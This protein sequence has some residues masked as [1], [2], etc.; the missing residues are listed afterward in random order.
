MATPNPA[1]IQYQLLHIREDRSKDIVN[2][3]TICMVIAIV[4]VALRFVSRR[5]CKVAILAD[6]Y[7]CLAALVSLSQV[8]LLWQK[9]VPIC[10][11]EEW[12][13]DLLGLR[14]WGGNR[15]IDV[16]VRF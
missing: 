1:E 16:Y 14:C 6:D 10:V 11:L 2:S 8:L 12:C 3:N 15:R 4:A 5:L 13:A 7:V 9:T